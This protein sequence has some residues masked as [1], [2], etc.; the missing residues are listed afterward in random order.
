M[1]PKGCAMGCEYGIRKQCEALA[2]NYPFCED[3]AEARSDPHP[4]PL[5]EP[6]IKEVD[7][8]KLALNE[9]V[10][11]RLAEVLERYN[12]G[13]VSMVAITIVSPDGGVS[14]CHSSTKNFNLLIGGMARHLHA[15]YGYANDG[16]E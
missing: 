6:K 1:K 13:R 9:T 15:M 12:Q 11:Q 4:A 16:D 7:F 14:M 8:T 10:P 5:E 3:S 2:C